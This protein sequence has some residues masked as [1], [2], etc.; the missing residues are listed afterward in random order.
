MADTPQDTA[1]DG[2]VEVVDNPAERFYELRVDGEPAG[3]LVYESAGS[4]RV[5][6]H[7]VIQRG[8]QGRG[9]SGRL[10]RAALDDLRARHHTVTSYCEVVDRFIE[11]HPEYAD[12]I[13]PEQPGAGH[14]G[15]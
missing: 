13:D 7:T 12:L 6:T 3:V 8:F 5:I 2:H 9:L 1:G 10:V 11:A 14:K 15:R 4:R